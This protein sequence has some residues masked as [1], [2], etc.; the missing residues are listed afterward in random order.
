MRPTSLLRVALAALVPAALV[1][2]TLVA[3]SAPVTA[4]A[5]R[6]VAGIYQFFPEQAAFSGL[7]H[8]PADRLGDNSLDAVRRWQRLEDRLATALDAQPRP[9]VG[10]RD[11]VTH[12]FLRAALDG[13]RASRICRSELWPLNQAFGWQV[14]MPQLT[15]L[16]PVGTD[17]ARAAA[18]RRW[19]QLP[20][21]VRAEIANLREGLRLGYT[22]PAGVV[23][24]VIGQL[25]GLLATPADR[26][27]FLDPVARDTSAGFIAAFRPLVTDSVRAI[28]GEY[29]TF[30]STEYLPK[31]RKGNAVSANPNGRACYRALLRQATSVDKDPDA[32][33]REVTAQ[34][35]RNSAALMRLAREVYP[36]RNGERADIRWLRTRLE[37]DPGNEIAGADSVRAFTQAAMDRARAAIPQWFQTVPA[38]DVTIVPFPDYQQS[39]APGGQYIP[40]VDGSG[41][42]ATYLYR[43]YPPVRP[44]ALEGTIF[45]ETWPGHHLQNATIGEQKERHPITRLVWVAGFGEGWASYTERLADELGLYGTPLT[46]LGVHL[47]LAPLMVANIGM[48]SRGWTIE[49]AQ[50][51]VRRQ[52]PSLADQRI[53]SVVTLLARSPATSRPTSWAPPRSAGSGP[54][55]SSR[56][57]PGSTS[58][59]FI[60]PR[61]RTARFRSRCW[62]RRSVGGWQ[63]G[64]QPRSAGGS[65][66]RVSRWRMPRSASWRRPASETSTSSSCTAS[67]IRTGIHADGW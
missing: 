53:A 48:Q 7:A 40:A 42:P 62:R 5:D 57:A 20:R 63:A 61:S 52:L 8:A 56:S 25:D 18:L 4:L 6:Y 14:S 23:R 15:A 34:V 2:A 26:L 65:S 32:L 30:L 49:Q 44:A 60:R 43:T 64:E 36:P 51:Y 10:S 50:A 66:A 1:P 67:A 54:R 19:R 59:R 58:A 29:R 38:G 12:G 45:H 33:W 37:Q 21:Y 35:S 22:A 9:A 16:Q 28:A 3:Q 13:G 11:W 55:P 41:R 47:T 24:A 39:T 17:S 46:R 31:A 27:P